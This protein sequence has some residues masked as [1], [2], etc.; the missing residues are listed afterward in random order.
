MKQITLKINLLEWKLIP[1]RLKGIHA[2]Y[3]WLFLEIKID[4]KL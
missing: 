4:Y 3:A 2:I 1:K